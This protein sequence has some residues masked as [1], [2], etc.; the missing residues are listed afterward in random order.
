MA[1]ALASWQLCCNTKCVTKLRLARAEFSKGLRNG[2]ALDATL[3]KLV[4]RLASKRDSLDLL[5]HMENLQASLVVHLLNLGS[6]LKDLLSF[7]LCDTSYIQHLL[8]GSVGLQKVSSVEN[9]RT[10]Q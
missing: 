7:R 5:P 3:K 8:F 6:D 2:L 10:S 9:K 1:A 4:Q